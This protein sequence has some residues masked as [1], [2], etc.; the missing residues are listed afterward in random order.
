MNVAD[1][2]R[3]SGNSLWSPSGSSTWR[4]YEDAPV[5]GA[6]VQSGIVSPAVGFVDE[7]TG[8]GS[9][10]WNVP[11]ADHVRPIRFSSSA[12]TRQ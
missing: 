10:R 1:A 6:H 8:A 12:R 2:E 7:G 5:I 9:R 4:S 11:V 3:K